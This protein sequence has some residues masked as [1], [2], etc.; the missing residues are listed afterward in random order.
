MQYHIY[1]YVDAEPVEF[2]AR[3]EQLES[4]L[5]KTDVLGKILHMVETKRCDAQEALDDLMGSYIEAGYEGQ[6]VRYAD[7][8][9]EHK[10]T[11]KL[12]K[13]KEFV[14]AE[15]EIR[16]YREGKGNRQGCIVLR[17]KTE[18]GKEFDSSVKG[19][20]EYVSKLY[21]VGD[22]LIGLMATIKYQRLTPDGIPKFLTCI[23]FKNKQ[24]D[25]VVPV[26]QLTRKKI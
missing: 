11:D 20:V 12:L 17:C 22:S 6:M 21:T 5:G 2:S 9:Y 10:R 1:D 7:S 24:G 3:T 4:Y 14:D 8:V 16:G 26:N 25:E 18:D 13:R 23:K 19:S 15:Y